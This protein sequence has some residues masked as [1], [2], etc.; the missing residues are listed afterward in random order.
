[1]VKAYNTRFS[2]SDEAEHL[3]AHA[4]V[5][6]LLAEEL[7][8]TIST[9]EF[10]NFDLAV[11]GMG[12]HHFDNLEL[13]TKRLVDRLKPGGVFLIIDFVTHQ[14]EDSPAIHTIAHHG[15]DQHQVEK[16]FAGAGLV[17]IGFVQMDG[18]VQMPNRSPRTPFL[19][20]GR[21]P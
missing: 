17:E 3:N 8:D 13:A 10:F 19:A 16:I 5:G 12:F 4:F 18:Q 14:K 2:P 7:P 11:V 9:P 21:K 15:F 1:M 6:N 20:R